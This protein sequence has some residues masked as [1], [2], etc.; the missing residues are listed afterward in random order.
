M[1]IRL[2]FST[3]GARIIELKM[4]DTECDFKVVASVTIHKS[5]CYACD[6]QPAMK[7]G[8]IP[9]KR[10]VVSTSFYDKL[11]CVWNYDSEAEVE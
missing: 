4:S 10:L 5:M 2:T 9:G 3:V 6:V 7:S 1:I 11:L 8:E